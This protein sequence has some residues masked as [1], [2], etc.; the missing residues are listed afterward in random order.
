MSAP[1]RRPRRSRESGK[2]QLPP[3]VTG[4]IFWTA[5]GVAG[6]QGSRGEERGV[7]RGA[8]EVVPGVACLP[9]AGGVERAAA[10]ESGAVGGSAESSDAPWSSGPRELASCPRRARP[11][12][13]T[14]ARACP[15][16]APGP[17]TPRL[18][19][20]RSPCLAPSPPLE[21]APGPLPEG[22]D[23]VTGRCWGSFVQTHSPGA[24]APG[25][26]AAGQSQ[27]DSWGAARKRRS[28]IPPGVGA[29]LGERCAG[30]ERVEKSPKQSDGDLMR[31]KK[32]QSQLCFLPVRLLPPK[33]VPFPLDV[34]M[35]KGVKETR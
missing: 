23:A 10:A 1:L 15:S 26:T 6:P 31:L 2:G 16:F 14:C 22:E 12:V 24:L 28:P 27:L 33:R 5:D 30:L 32:A 11:W 19:A 21:V 35:Q 34:I 4:G 20:S 29:W 7:W 9:S 18:V 8:R 3:A 17:H 25:R 13:C